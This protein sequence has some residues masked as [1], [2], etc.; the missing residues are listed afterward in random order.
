MKTNYLWTTWVSI[1]RVVSTSKIISS[2][3][4][5][6]I[7][8][9]KVWSKKPC[10][11]TLLIIKQRVKFIW[12]HS[13]IRAI[14]DR[15]I[16]KLNLSKAVK[17]LSRTIIHSLLSSNLGINRDLRLQRHKI[18]ME[19]QDWMLASLNLLWAKLILRSSPSI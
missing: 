5:I 17:K 14:E 11:F 4:N 9:K 12:N 18:N 15:G 16:S 3:F 8:L 13:P 10:S 2:S 6:Q 1:V 19:W 7:S